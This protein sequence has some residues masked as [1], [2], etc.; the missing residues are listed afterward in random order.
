MAAKRS[1]V[2]ERIGFVSLLKVN[3]ERYWV[4]C[5][6]E[7]IGQNAHL[8]QDLPSILVLDKPWFFLI[9]WFFLLH[10]SSVSL[11][12]AFGLIQGPLVLDIIIAV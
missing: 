2:D 8:L 5:K 1:Q 10:V 12:V 9:V 7:G 4:A 3:K 11:A 6:R